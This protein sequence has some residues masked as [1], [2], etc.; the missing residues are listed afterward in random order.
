MRGRGGG[1]A[2]LGHSRH[3][4]VKSL[5][6]GGWIVHHSPREGLSGREAVQAFT[7]IGRVVSDAPC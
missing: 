6:E 4:A 5:K 1:F 7:T 2:Q 3:A